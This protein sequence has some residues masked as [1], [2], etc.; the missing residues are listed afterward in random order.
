M[1]LRCGWA[2]GDPMYEK[3]HDEEWAV[4]LY[5][6]TLLF[7][8]LLLEGFQAGLSWITILKKRDH[9][10]R[11]MDA[12]NPEKIARY[13]EAKIQ[14]LLT[15]KGIIRNQSKIR[16]AVSNARCFLSLQ[17][18]GRCFS[19]Y[20]WSFVDGKVIEHQFTS[21]NQ[22]PSSDARSIQM[23]KQ[24]KKDGF[25]FVGPTICYAFMQ[26]TGMVNDHLVSCFRHQ[27]CRAI[28]DF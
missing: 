8:F 13:D 2:D 23:S 21:L 22:V 24:L 1:K 17:D 10:R 6:D 15:D 16:G 7:E 27:E 14:V 3:Y 26:A 19:D 5:D 25:T 9:Y 11:V 12:F 20:V 28:N 4:P 18:D